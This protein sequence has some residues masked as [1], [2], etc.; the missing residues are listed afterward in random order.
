VFSKMWLHKTAGCTEF[1][2]ISKRRVSV[3]RLSR[4]QTSHF[5]FIL[6]CKRKKR[7][8]IAFVHCQRSR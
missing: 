5:G 1:R 6:E 3:I 7:R 4:A 8:R 2:S